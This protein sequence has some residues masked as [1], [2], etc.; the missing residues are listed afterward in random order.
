MIMPSANTTQS[1]LPSGAQHASRAAT[2]GLHRSVSL[3]C[4]QSSLPKFG[5]PGHCA[6]LNLA[7]PR[8]PV[9]LLVHSS[10]LAYTVSQASTSSTPASAA[11]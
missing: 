11:A 10:K 2:A 8:Q 1:W 7:Q 5:S 9:H 4:K 6:Y 3:V